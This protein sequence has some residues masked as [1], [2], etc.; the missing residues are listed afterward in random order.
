MFNIEPEMQQYNRYTRIRTK[1]VKIIII[2]SKKKNIKSKSK[3]KEQQDDKKIS[4]KR[5]MKITSSAIY[6]RH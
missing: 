4:L 3:K 1:T 6:L 2:L 5:E